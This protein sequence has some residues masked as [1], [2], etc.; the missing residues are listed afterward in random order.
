MAKPYGTEVGI[1]YPVFSPAFSTNGNVFVFAYSNE[2]QVSEVVRLES[3]KVAKSDINNELA[4]LKAY[5]SE[6]VEWKS[7]DEMNIYGFFRSE[8]RKIL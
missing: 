3:G 5:P 4:N 2:K 7:S 1:V 6:L 8:N